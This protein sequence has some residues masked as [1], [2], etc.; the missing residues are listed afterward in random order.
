M[1]QL[2]SLIARHLLLSIT[3]GFIAGIAFGPSLKLKETSQTVLLYSLLLFLILILLLHLFRYSKTVYF[4]LFLFSV[5]LGILHIT[6]QMQIPAAPS[7]IYNRIVEKT[8]VVVVGTMST[9]ATFNGKTSTTIIK[10]QFVR[11]KESNKLLPTSG[12]IAIRLQGKWPKKFKPGD[13]LVIRT[14]L[15]RPDSYASPGSFDYARYLAEKN[16]WISGFI[17]SPLLIGQLHTPLTFSHKLRY[18]HERV[19]THIGNTIDRA[20]PGQ[21][22]GLYRAILLGDRTAVSQETLEFF[23]GSGTLHILAISGIHMTVLGTLLYF[24]FYW[25]LSR[26]EK[27][28]LYFPVPKLAAFL[29]IPPLLG[30]GLL[31]GM[32]NPVIRA[33]LMSSIVVLALCSDRKKSPAPL[34]ACAALVMLLFSPVQ[35]FT[36][37]FQ[38]SFA[39]ITGIIFIL[40]I[41]QNILSRETTESRQPQWFILC[42]RWL[43]AGLLVSIVATLAT[44]PFSLLLFNRI[45][46]VGP[47]ANIVVEPLVCL[48]ALPLGLFSIPV[49]SISPTLSTWL[50][51]IGGLGIDAALIVVKFFSGFSFSTWW[52]P[53]PPVWLIATYYLILVSTI[54]YKNRTEKILFTIV[55][56]IILCSFVLLHP[57]QNSAIFRKKLARYCF[58]DVGQGTATLLEFGSGRRV[59]IDGGGSSFGNVKVGERVIAPYLW[60]KGIRNLDTIIITHPDADHYNGLRFIVQHFSPSKI[61]IRKKDDGDE[62]FKEFLLGAAQSDVEINVPTMGEQLL[63]GEKSLECLFNFGITSEEKN[64]QKSRNMKNSGLIIRACIDKKCAIFPGDIE[65][66]AERRLLK[67]NIDLKSDILLAAHHGSKTSNSVE[68]LDRV[69][70]VTIVVSAGSS[71]SNHFPHPTLISKA[72]KRRTKLFNTADLGTIEFLFRK[73]TTTIFH[74]EKFDNNPLY[75]FEKTVLQQVGSSTRS[76]SKKEYRAATILQ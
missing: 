69:D 72:V 51:Q 59:L 11:F 40:P 9:M 39:A 76:S 53:T 19:R 28:L 6:L 70:P 27:L 12:K 24:Q 4:T 2:T 66:S 54:F 17:P 43:V 46:L 15:K 57:I 45:S 32:N 3:I 34:L 16:I 71:S 14:K 64:E 1:K 58:L 30:Y 65:L 29:Y 62:N 68:F 61:Y 5:A 63:D 10:S 20:L 35:L 47:L 50:L 44:A 42:L 26:S 48:W 49:S 33:I 13:T 8:E 21:Q 31:A 52:L 22:S 25:L 41:L 36:A 56:L 23:K 60:S 55:T 7:H 18:L 75:P 73:D 37:S 74:Y 38:L 67:E